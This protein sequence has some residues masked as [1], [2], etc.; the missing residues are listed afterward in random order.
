MR[1]SKTR[2]VLNTTLTA[3]YNL[4]R[5]ARLCR[6]YLGNGT[7]LSRSCNVIGS[8][9]WRIRWR[10]YQWPW[11]LLKV[12]LTVRDLSNCLTSRNRA[13][14]KTMCLDANR[15]AHVACNFNC[16]I[17][18][19]DFSRSQ[20]ITCSLELVISGKRCEI[21]TFLLE[22]VDRKWYVAYKIAS[23]PMNFNDLQGHAIFHIV[24]DMILTD[25]WRRAVPLS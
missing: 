22:T 21:R 8:H 14:Y 12:T 16:R 1:G 9:M 10:E 6:Q 15:K 5:D 18:L 25:M 19:K 13:Y 17:K 24:V 3:I 4:A 20:T 7:R 23:F 11:M 2:A